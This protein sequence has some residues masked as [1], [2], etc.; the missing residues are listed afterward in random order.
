MPRLTH[1]VC[2]HFRRRCLV[3]LNKDLDEELAFIEA[4]ARVTAKN[5]Q[6]WYHRRVVVERSGKATREFAFTASVFE[7][8]AKN[9]HAWAHRQWVL[10]KF[11]EWEGELAVVDCEWFGPVGALAL[12]LTRNGFFA[13]ML[14]DDVRNNSAWNQRWFVIQN[15]TG[16]CYACCPGVALFFCLRD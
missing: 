3:E 7:E 1:V 8:D 6:L 14:K 15:T 16:V 12:A 2:R 9:Y 4:Q 5:Y 11:G 13:A 10:K